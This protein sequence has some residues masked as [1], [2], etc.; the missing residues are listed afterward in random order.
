MP[1]AFANHKYIIRGDIGNDLIRAAR[2][3]HFEARAGFG[4]EAEM[5]ARTFRALLGSC[6][7]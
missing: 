7:S 2:L 1:V 3:T 4:A 5:Q 6:C